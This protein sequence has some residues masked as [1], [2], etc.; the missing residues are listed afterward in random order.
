MLESL[1]TL[2]SRI[3]Y[4]IGCFYIYSSSR[5][6]AW[7]SFTSFSFI[8]LPISLFTR[9]LLFC[10]SFCLFLIASCRRASF[11]ILLS[12]PFLPPMLSTL[13]FNPIPT[14]C[15]YSFTRCCFYCPTASTTPLLPL[16]ERLY[17]LSIK[18]LRLFSSPSRP[19]AIY[20]I[21]YSRS[22]PTI[23]YSLPITLHTRT[24]SAFWIISQ[25]RMRTQHPT[26]A[27]AYSLLD[28][29]LS[30][31]FMR[32]YCAFPSNFTRIL[33]IQLRIWKLAIW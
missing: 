3:L 1:L 15:V 27:A 7:R 17:S 13:S 4:W 11:S 22:P 5:G 2:S 20:S 31:N 30:M 24:I 12:L 25:P 33:P 28:S 21:I 6:I 26:K 16:L 32:F 9:I 18:S 29:L 10:W 19:W 23:S 8:S 14:W